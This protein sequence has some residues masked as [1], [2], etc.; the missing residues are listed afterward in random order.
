M[1]PS[2][3]LAKLSNNYYYPWFFRTLP[4]LV[5]SAKT[6]VALARHFNWTRVGIVYYG[7]DWES[8]VRVHLQSDVLLIKK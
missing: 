4:A 2:A 7:R 1:S 5:D 8:E 6:F 3:S